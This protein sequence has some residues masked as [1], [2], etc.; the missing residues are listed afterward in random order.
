M[1]RLEQ[2]RERKRNKKNPS[3]NNGI[4]VKKGEIP[5]EKDEILT[6]NDINETK[7]TKQTKQT[8]TN[9]NSPASGEADF[10]G[11]SH[12]EKSALSLA[13]T[14]LKEHR[15]EIP[16]YLAGKDAQVIQRWAAD[17]EKLIRIDK[18]SPENIRDV[19]FWVKTP[20]NFW[21][22]N[23]E[24]GAKLRKHF[25]R[26][27]GQMKTEKHGQGPPGHWDTRN[28]PDISQPKEVI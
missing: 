26:L 22:H 14:I 24:S 9:R 18:K 20:G 21:F 2:E 23:I 6:E 3:E 13:E 10:F 7:Q 11:N 17:I 8:K 27:F 28:M 4:P 12:E 1:E 19:I 5:P 15:K 16:D 25:E